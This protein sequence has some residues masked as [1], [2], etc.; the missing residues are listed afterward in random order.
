MT[1]A[2]QPVSCFAR[3]CGKPHRLADGAPLCHS[4]VLLPPFALWA[5]AEGEERLASLLLAKR[6]AFGP[7][8]RHQG[9]WNL[10][11]R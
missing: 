4:C 10:R 8:P 7:L 5:E 3:F 11:R 2:K 9:I 1:G 6:A